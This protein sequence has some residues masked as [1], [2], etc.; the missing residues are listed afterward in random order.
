MVLHMLW[1]CYNSTRNG[2]LKMMMM[3]AGSCALIYGK[4][5]KWLLISENKLSQLILGNQKP[6]HLDDVAQWAQRYRG[7]PRPPWQ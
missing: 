4:I 3:L 1:V 6:R 2:N 5:P 7:N